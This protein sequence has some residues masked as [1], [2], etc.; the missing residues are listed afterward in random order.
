LFPVYGFYYVSE[1]VEKALVADLVPPELRGTAF[2]VYNFAV[3]ITVLPASL[4]MGVLWDTVGARTAFLV[5]AALAASAAGIFALKVEE[6][7][8]R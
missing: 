6:G 4:L 3:S 5:G 7:Q 8:A 1:A 2:G